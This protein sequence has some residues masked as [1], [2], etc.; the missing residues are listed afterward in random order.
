MPICGGGDLYAT[1][2]LTALPIWAFHGEDDD[3]VPV[4]ESIRIV[5]T[6]QSDDGQQVKLTLYPKVGH[7]SWEM[8][9]TDQT[10]WDWLFEQKHQ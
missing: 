7:N 9:Y 8:T 1:W 4:E 3:V 10:M 5:E 2:R 6:I